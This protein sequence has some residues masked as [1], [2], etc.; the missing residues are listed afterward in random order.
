MMAEKPRRIEDEHQ[1]RADV[2]QRGDDG[3][4][5]PEKG[6]QDADSIDAD[7]APEVEHDDAVTAFADRKHLR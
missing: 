1:L 2:D 4:E 7:R 3:R 5:L 6:K